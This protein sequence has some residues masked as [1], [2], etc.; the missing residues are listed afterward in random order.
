MACKATPRLDMRK[1]KRMLLDR[2]NAAEWQ[3]WTELVQRS[4]NELAD[5][6][7]QGVPAEEEVQSW[8]LIERALQLSSKALEAMQP[9]AAMR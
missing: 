4:L 3:G 1:P 6:P 5:P 2:P 8:L 9:Q 7:E